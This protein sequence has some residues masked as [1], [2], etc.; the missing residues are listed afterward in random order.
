MELINGIPAHVLLVHLVVVLV[1]T[2]AALLVGQA[3]VPRLRRWA[4]PLG[5]LLCLGALVMVPLTTSSGNWLQDNLPPAPLIEEH[6]DLGDNLLPWVIGLLVMS[7]L[8][9]LVHRQTNRVDV[10]QGAMEPAKRH[11]PAP[12]AILVAVLATAVAAGASY[13]V[14]R[15]GESGARAVWE[16]ATNPS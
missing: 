16:G 8:V 9:Q 6:A 5:P 1:P 11:R 10:E 2:A 12:M 7:V 14:F 4:G 15:I 3:W 13:E